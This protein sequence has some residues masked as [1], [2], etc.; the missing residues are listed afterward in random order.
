MEVVFI[1]NKFPQE[2]LDFYKIHGVV[3]PTMNQIYS[4]REVR[5]D[6][7]KQ[8]LL[9]EGLNNPDVPITVGYK[10]I[11]IEPSWNIRRFA[12]L[13][14]DK[15]EQLEIEEFKELQKNETKKYGNQN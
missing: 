6:L 10:V 15:I 9:L 8:G 7:G 3:I 12:T 4:I 11:N 1:D 2:I 13:L 5:Y 14:G